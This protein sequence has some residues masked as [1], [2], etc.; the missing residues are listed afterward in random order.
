MSVR[1][2]LTRLAALVPRPR[3]NTTLY[4]GV[5]ASHAKHRRAVVPEPPDRP[6][7]HDASWAALMRHSFGLDVLSC[8]LCR[9][10]MRFT[11][12]LFDP[13]EV[14]RLLAH[15]HCFSDP[16]P[17][18]PSRGPPDWPDTLDFP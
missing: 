7:A 12:V 8:R 14:R 18:S 15:L 6:R 11:H 2:F 17:V 3:A 16:L 1:T 10:R 5:L 4:D 9:G 13:A